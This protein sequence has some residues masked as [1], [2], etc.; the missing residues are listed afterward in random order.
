[1]DEQVAKIIEVSRAEREAEAAERL[2]VRR[3]VEA[4]LKWQA[5]KEAER[6]RREENG[7]GNASIS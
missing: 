6:K 7:P 4:M 3:E 1:M 5:K 2:K